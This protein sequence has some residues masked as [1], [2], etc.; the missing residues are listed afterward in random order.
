MVAAASVLLLAGCS[1]RIQG[2]PAVDGA[3]VSTTAT[4]ASPSSS[5]G[6]PAEPPQVDSRLADVEPCAL[7]DPAGL[8]SLGLTGGS[9]ESIG[10]A[11]V[12]RYRHEGRTLKETFTVSVEIFETYGITDIVGR[13]IRPL[14]KMGSHDA[15]LF[16]EPTGGC[17]VSLAVTETSRIDNTAHGGD[18]QLACRFATRLAELVEPNLR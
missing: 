18:Q 5:T 2:S 13:D 10:A 4:V 11:R 9:A 16:L 1:E 6:S 8:A 3:A 14:P 12:C 7:A 15:V 17:A